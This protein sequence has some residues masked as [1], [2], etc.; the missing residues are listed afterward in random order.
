MSK[1]PT[2]VVILGGGIGGV[3]AAREVRSAIPAD[4][5]VILV[6][7]Q[8]IQSFPPSYTWVMTGQR[9]PAAISRDLRGL[10]RKGIEVVEGSAS[11]VDVAGRRISGEGFEVAFD[12]LVVALGAELAPEAVPGL[13]GEAFSYYRL[14]DAE[15][16]RDELETFNGGKV[17]LLIPSLP[18][19][20]PA[21]PYEGAMLL[22]ALFRNRGIR[23]RVELSLS[24]P[25][26]QPLPVAGSA[27]G[28]AVV[29]MLERKEI[30]YH[31]QRKTTEI[32]RAAREIV[33][34]DGAREAYDLLIAVPPH[35]P[36]AI[37]RESQIA[38]P[39]GWAKV[40]SGLLLT[41]AP[42]VYAIG[43]VT[44][45]PLFDGM[46]LPKAGVFAHA[47]A[48]VVA[49]NIAAEIRGDDERRRFDGHGYCFLEVG[50]G[51]AA[52]A[53]GDFY[54]Q[55]RQV[56]MKDPTRLRRL[57]KMLFERWWLWKWY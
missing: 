35:R 15:R 42:Q 11:T 7:R 54:G 6:D 27:L 22:D 10:R 25:E 23:N 34:E 48:N 38:G 8:P 16:L 49:H 36:P 57:G 19:K 13:A 43:D 2:S 41:D 55:P 33:F 52:S 51:K 44:A 26:P 24:T 14:A 53:N 21:A 12:Y 18:Y 3:V 4:T 30:A 47:E 39:A 40:D 5:R 50:G 17:A 46:M 45:I 56:A 20:C 32:D 31:P 29:S 28:Q 9:Q 37:V 1:S